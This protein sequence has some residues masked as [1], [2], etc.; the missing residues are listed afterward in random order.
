[1]QFSF[2]RYISNPDEIE[3]DLMKNHASGVSGGG[4]VSGGNSSSNSNSL[5]STTLS[6]LT[7]SKTSSFFSRKSKRKDDSKSSKNSRL[8]SPLKDA[9]LSGG[10]AAA[11]TTANSLFYLNTNDL[12][13]ATSSSS[14]SPASGV[15][16]AGVSATSSGIVT[17]PSNSSPHLSGIGGGSGGCG[18]SGGGDE[19]DAST[20]V[21]LILKD[22]QRLEGKIRELGLD[23]FNEDFEGITVSTTKCLSC[24]TITEQKETM[25][26]IAVPVPQAGYE[27]NEFMDRPSS[28]IQVSVGFFFIVNLH[29]LTF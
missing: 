7:S 5:A 12:N 2:V 4:V 19:T 23:F 20:A 3:R 17:S 28:F 11:T 22:K 21:A 10:N 18:V 26:D 6:S 25:I 8:Q 14:T 9:L 29:N 1:M 24:E 13:S 16:M 27:S 15:A